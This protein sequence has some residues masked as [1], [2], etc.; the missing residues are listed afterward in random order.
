[1]VL[2]SGVGEVPFTPIMDRYPAMRR[3]VAVRRSPVA[4]AGIAVVFV[5][6]SVLLRWAI[7]ISIAGAPFLTFYPAIVLVT[8]FGGLW[9]GVLAAVYPPLLPGPSFCRWLTLILPRE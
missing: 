8:W 9:P 3:A 6:F 7:G 1:M 5:A 2:L 4:G